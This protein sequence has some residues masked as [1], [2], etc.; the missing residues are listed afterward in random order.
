VACIAVARGKLQL[1]VVRLNASV[2]LDVQNLTPAYR[3]RAAIREVAVTHVR[4]WVPE[5]C[6]GLHT[7]LGVHEHGDVQ[8]IDDTVTH[9]LIV[10]C[11]I[12]SLSKQNGRIGGVQLWEEP[13]AHFVVFVGVVR[14]E[15]TKCPRRCEVQALKPPIVRQVF[16]YRGAV[17]V[18]VD[19]TPERVVTLA[20]LRCRV[21][22]LHQDEL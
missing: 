12:G 9:Y 5:A 16:K 6:I 15:A 2:A 18:P 7:K 21:E 20:G 13:K 3:W 17:I 10:A 14:I 22:L 11:A 4:N 8:S 1:V 19:M